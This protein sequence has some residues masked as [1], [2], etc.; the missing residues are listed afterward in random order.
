MSYLPVFTLI[1]TKYYSMQSEST[2]R[3]AINGAHKQRQYRIWNCGSGFQSVMS[4]VSHAKSWSTVSAKTSICTIEIRNLCCWY[5]SSYII[6]WDVRNQ[7][8]YN[9]MTGKLACTGF[10]Y[11][12]CLMYPEPPN[13]CIYYQ[14]LW[15]NRS[16]SALRIPA[17][18]GI[19]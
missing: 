11:S 9:A 12:V 8:N 15:I 19:L 2:K 6:E 4:L 3:R 16:K 5:S 13:A 14:T 10:D 7:F 1:W 18:N 17:D